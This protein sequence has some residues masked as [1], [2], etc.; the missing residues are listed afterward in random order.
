MFVAFRKCEEQISKSEKLL[1]ELSRND[2]VDIS[3][4][5]N[6]NILQ[7]LSVCSRLG[8]VSGTG[9]NHETT[10]NPNNG[11][12]LQDRAEHNVKMDNESL[13]C[14]LSGI[15]D[16]SNSELMVTDFH[17]KCVK[18]LDEAYTVIDVL[19]VRAS[20]YSVCSCLL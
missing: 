9:E 16:T 17:K 6:K 10:P 3:F 7:F 2:Y 15:C 19:H 4:Y 12:H 20:P 18:L 5:P 14:S 13:P 1:Q 11:V 8:E